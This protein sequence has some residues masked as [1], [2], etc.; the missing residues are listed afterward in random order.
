MCYNLNYKQVVFIIFYFV[1]KKQYLFLGA[2]F[3]LIFAFLTVGFNKVEAATGTSTALYKNQSN[4]HISIYGQVSALRL[5]L[6]STTTPPENLDSV[7][8]TIATS[9]NAI[10]T[11]VSTSSFEWVG[12]VKDNDANGVFSGSDIFLATTTVNITI[13]TTVN[14]AAATTTPAIG[15]F[16]IVFKTASSTY[17]TDNGAPET[18]GKVAQAIIVKISTNGVVA[19]LTPATINTTTTQPFIADTHSQAPDASKVSAQYQSGAYKIFD[20]NGDGGVGELGFLNVYSTSTP[21]AS[22]IATTTVSANGNFTQLSI[23]STYLSSVWLDLNDAA[24]NATSSKV[25]YNLPALP[26]V[27]SIAGFTDRI[28]INTN[29]NLRGDQATLCSNYTLNGNALACGN[30]SQPFIEFSGNQMVIKNLSLTQ[31]S[32]ASLSIS[33]ITDINPESFPFT[34]STTTL[35]VNTASLPAISLVSP[36]SGKAGDTVTIT[37]SNFGTATGTVWFSGGFSQQTGPLQPIQATSTAWS[38]TSITVAVPTGANSGPLTVVSSGGMMSDVGGNSFFDVVG[39]VYIK[40]ALAT[41]GSPIATSTDM[42]IFIGDKTGEHIY[43]V[44]DNSTTTF[45]AANYYY[46]IP[47]ISSEGFTWAYDVSGGKVSSAGSSL[48][49][50]TSTSSPQILIFSTSTT[51]MATGAITLGSPCSSIGQNKWVA[52][53][54]MPSGASSTMSGP[55]EVQPSFFKTNGSCTVDYNLA[56]A[57]NGL[58]QV[59]AHLPP[60]A[61]STPLLD[62]AGQQINI[63]DAGPTATVNLTFTSATRKINGQVVNASS[64]SLGDKN[65]DLWVFANQPTSG[66]KSSVS[67]PDGSGNFSLYA[68]V[69]SYKIGVGGP[70]MPMGVER[71]IIVTDSAVF[72]TTSTQVA[73]TIKLEPPTSYISGYVKDGSG[74]AVSGIDISAWCEGS[75]AGGHSVSDSQGFYKMYVPACSNYHVSGFSQSY[76]QLAEQ[77]SVVVGPSS[78]PT[79]N[80]TLSSDNFVNITGSVTQNSSALSGADVWI[81]QGSFGPSV[82]WAKTSSNG[83][84]SAKIRKGLSNLYL[85]AAL[86]GQGEIANQS[87]NGGSAI[88]ADLSVGAISA[89]VATIEI[90]LKPINT[91]ATGTV[92]IGA[93]SSVG[94]GFTNTKEGT[95]ADYDIYRIRVPY[96]GSTLYMID[97]GIQNFGP[98]PQATTTVSGDKTITI[99]LSSVSFYNVSGTVTSTVSGAVSDAFVWAGGSAGGGGAKTDAS[100]NFSFKLRAGTYDIG[101][102]QPGYSGSM[103]ASLN[104]NAATSSLNLTLTQN[105]QTITGT[106]KYSGSA[107]SNARVWADNGSGGWA[108]ATSEADGS[109]TLN[110]SSGSWNVNAIA[111]GYQLSSPQVTTAPASGVILNMTAV[112]FNAKRST[113]SVTPTQGGVIQTDDAKV[114]IPQGAL[115]TSG[116]AVQMDVT[117][118]MSTPTKKGGRVVG[119]AKSI[120]ATYASGDNQGQQITTL[121]QN[122]TIEI[123]LTKA[124]LEDKNISTI[125]AAQKVKIGYDDPTATSWT[126]IPTTVILNP[127]TST[128]WSD[129]VSITLKGTTSHF[130]TF[131]PISPSSAEAPPTPTG[132]SATAGAERISLNWTASTGAAKYDIYRKSGNDYPYLA[133]TVNTSYTDSGLSAHATYYY[134]VTALDNSDNESS[135]TD[136]VS[137]TALIYVGVGGGGGGET[138][139]VTLIVATTTIATTTQAVATTTTPMATTTALTVSAPEISPIIFTTPVAVQKITK[140]LVLGSRGDEIKTIQD[141]L[142]QD[143]E[144]YPEGLVTGYFGSLTKKAIQKFQEKYGIAKEGEPGY[145]DVGPNTRAKINQILAGAAGPAAVPQLPAQSSE[146]TKI[147]QQIKTQLQTLQEQLVQLLAELAKKLQ[148]QVQQKLG[149]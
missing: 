20:T 106:V 145:G 75:P 96:S 1:M 5:E 51:K 142:A 47:N 82:G 95:G 94:G 32:S 113:Q 60:S 131:A 132:F 40:L 140:R 28:I 81:T 126:E 61:T 53:F 146:Q 89:S 134:K 18:G 118:T 72:N 22:A 112:S 70:G 111:D 38:A 141:L 54:A 25:Q 45:D 42:R 108:G 39:N 55:G 80:F 65:N 86:M 11:E 9:T 33:G 36:S 16:F 43:Y 115:G 37:G 101:V 93:H 92:F 110:V 105:S 125:T 119:T 63:S 69:G 41:S 29:K 24:G 31:G 120:Q 50:N 123:V 64:G 78:N 107:L 85:H 114:E 88:D 26:S 46:T 79:V 71:D 137:A 124:Q 99:D 116:T 19:S 83:N 8:I 49:Q 135:A 13:P 23:G 147:V 149:Q 6:N 139:A 3:A 117:D 104:I 143:K 98:I 4:N 87:L 15:N 102:G 122:V 68:S 14:I 58:Y 27:S 21:G 73:I 90:R 121:S 133:Q 59:E 130:S 74:N 148:E 57:S 84:F 136:A 35:A 62:P 10:S 77:T 48:S 91:F 76:G 12:V 34:Y 7:T 138:P 103:L 100:G 66:G 17:W 128:L 30:P 129:L 44:G 144:V 67:R 97:G 56:L 2:I 109:F 127:A 52:V